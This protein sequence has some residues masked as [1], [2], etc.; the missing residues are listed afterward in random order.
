[1]SVIRKTDAEALLS[2]AAVLDLSDLARQA[3]A[4]RARAQRQAG[5]ILEQAQARHDKLV[6]EGH[7]KGYAEGLA[8]GHAEGLAKG[9]EE[10]SKG[11]IKETRE[12]AVRL[13]QG[14]AEALVRFEKDR[15][16]MLSQARQDVLFLALEI[17]RRITRRS[18]RLD[19]AIIGTLIEEALSHVAAPTQVEVS[20]R[21]DEEQLAAEMLPAIAAT[22]KACRQVGLRPDP[23]LP[24][25]SVIVRGAGGGE[26]DA[27]VETQL[28]RITEALSVA[29]PAG[30]T[31]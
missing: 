13:E 11:A 21:A 17:A 15:S 28:A 24:P 10:G 14:W 22:F 7:A 31:P 20:V 29:D 1:M 5:E 9:R 25:G 18:L 23:A 12:R 27:S 26:V 19:P 8:K 30:G 4:I 3:E 2:K 16:A 6:A